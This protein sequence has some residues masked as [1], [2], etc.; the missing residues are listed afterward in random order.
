MSTCCSMIGRTSL[1]CHLIDLASPMPRCIYTHENTSL[2]IYRHGDISYTQICRE[3]RNEPHFLKRFDAIKTSEKCIIQVSSDP[4]SIL[5]WT[6]AQ[7]I[8]FTCN[9]YSLH[10]ATASSRGGNWFCLQPRQI[11]A[12]VQLS[13]FFVSR[14]FLSLISGRC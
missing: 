1:K 5:T 6:P 14:H 8:S 12:V 11:L 3:S 7:S 13:L 2:Y 9:L 10:A 4:V